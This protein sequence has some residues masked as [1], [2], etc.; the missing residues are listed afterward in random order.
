MNLAAEHILLGSPLTY[1][2][3]YLEGVVR[4][5]F[6]PGSTE[7]LRFFDLYPKEGGLLDVA[8]DSGITRTIQVLFLNPLLAWSTVVL[9]L[10]QL[11]I[12]AVHA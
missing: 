10:L 3:I 8:V 5:T 11:I 1:A 4:S 12:S 6:D 7:F 2:R 9:L